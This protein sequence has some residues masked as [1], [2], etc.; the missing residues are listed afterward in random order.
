MRHARLAARSEHRRHHGSSDRRRSSSSTWRWA[1]RSSHRLSSR[2]ARCSRTAG[3]RVL[4]TPGDVD[5][6]V[7]G[8]KVVIDSPEL[9]GPA[10]SGRTGASGPA[11]HVAGAHAADRRSARRSAVPDARTV[12]RW[13]RKA[14]SMPPERDCADRR[15]QAD[16]TRQRHDRPSSGHAAADI[17]PRRPTAGRA[18]DVRPCSSRR[19]PGA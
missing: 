14:L 1:S 13:A 4:V 17:L 5:D 10:R 2:S 12:R 15:S 16:G 3:P 6:L 19:D 7:R 18:G 9:A 8:M 11:P